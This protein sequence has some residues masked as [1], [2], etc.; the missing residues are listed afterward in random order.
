MTIHGW[1]QLIEWSIEHSCMEDQLRRD[2]YAEWERRWY[3][4]CNWTI[5]NYGHLLEGGTPE[6]SLS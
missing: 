3:Q 2:I 4:F 6:K 5:E 1:R